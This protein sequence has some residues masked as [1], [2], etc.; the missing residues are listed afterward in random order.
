MAVHTSV[1]GVIQVAVNLTLA[2]EAEPSRQCT[3]AI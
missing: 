1:T 2:V 3:H